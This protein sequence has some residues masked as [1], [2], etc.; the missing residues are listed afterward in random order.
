MLLCHN[1]IYIVMIWGV[2]RMTYR[3]ALYWIIGFID[4]LYKHLVT[5]VNTALSLIYTLHSSPLHTH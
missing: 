5:T 4:T 2:L 1:F 3:R